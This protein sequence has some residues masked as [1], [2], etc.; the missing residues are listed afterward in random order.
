MKNQ[1]LIIIQIFKKR[2]TNFKPNFEK[3]NFKEFGLEKDKIKKLADIYKNKHYLINIY[4]Y[5]E[6]GDSFLDS[7]LKSYRKSKI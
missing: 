4:N 2:E 6:N 3:E 5:N 1:L 7:I